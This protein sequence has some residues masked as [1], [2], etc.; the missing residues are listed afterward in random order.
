M[1]LKNLKFLELSTPLGPMLTVASEER[2]LLLEFSDLQNLERKMERL[3][4]KTNS[5]ISSGR[6]KPIDSIEK[7]LFLYFKGKLRKFE[8]PLLFLGTPF[9]NRVWQQLAQIP[10][11]E[12]RSYKEIA[13]AIGCP[14]GYRAVARANST[15][16]LAIIIPCHR[17][18]NTGGALG[19]YAG[20]L[21]RKK[22]LLSHE[23]SAASK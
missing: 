8:T 11:G 12:T 2:L 23:K 17:V 20:G 6:S 19:G 18:I 21:S 4:R 9:Q 15:N 7:E 16:Q 14:S 3:S 10:F 13:C 22:W 1:T 5:S